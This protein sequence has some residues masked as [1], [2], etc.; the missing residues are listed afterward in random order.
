MV[1]CP[2][3]MYGQGEE[4][5]LLHPVFRYLTIRY[6]IYDIGTCPVCVAL[7]QV[8]YFCFCKARAHYLSKLRKLCLQMK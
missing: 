2:G 1:V 6:M 4:D 5:S 7:A 8:V 3:L